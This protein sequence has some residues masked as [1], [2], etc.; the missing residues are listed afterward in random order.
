VK[1][2]I[3]KAL[4]KLN[5]S[6]LSFRGQLWRKFQLFQ[7]NFFFIWVKVNWLYFRITLDFLFKIKSVIFPDQLRCLSLSCQCVVKMSW[8]YHLT[9]NI[10]LRRRSRGY[11]LADKLFDATLLPQSLD[12]YNG[13]EKVHLKSFE[14]RKIF[15]VLIDNFLFEFPYS[16]QFGPVDVK[17]LF[18]LRYL[19]FHVSQFF[20]FFGGGLRLLAPFSYFLFS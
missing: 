4:Y 6:C 13:A 14:G 2:Y 15:S 11:K 7:V 12:E 3:S 20:Q 5:H 19:N 10:A 1:S 18:L 8:W 17:L 9:C 16:V